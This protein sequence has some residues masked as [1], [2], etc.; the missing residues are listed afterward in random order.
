MPVAGWMAVIF[1]FSTG[2]FSADDTGAV[3]RPVLHAL[4]PWFSDIQVDV[5]HEAIRKCAHLTEY[6]ILALLWLRAVRRE[7]L[8]ARRAALIAMVAAVLYAALDEFHQT[9]EPSRTPSPIDVTIDSLG[10]AIALLVAHVGWRRCADA[11][12]GI[13]LWAAA[14]GGALILIVNAAAGVHSGILWL[15]VPAAA[16]LLLVRWRRSYSRS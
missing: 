7:G 16:L 8:P 12:S 9:F 4:L 5:A 2:S 6:G 15:T 10:A 13:L 11:A 1:W 14:V 3:L